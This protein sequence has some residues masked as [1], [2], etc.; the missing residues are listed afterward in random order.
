MRN[1]QVVGIT[2]PASV[3]LAWVARIRARCRPVD[4]ANEFSDLRETVRNRVSAPHIGARKISQTRPTFVP[5]AAEGRDW[6]TLASELRN[7]LSGGMPFAAI[8]R[9]RRSQTS[10]A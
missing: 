1:A 8:E 3:L 2:M 9:F 5:R 10:S 6:R 7:A 4:C